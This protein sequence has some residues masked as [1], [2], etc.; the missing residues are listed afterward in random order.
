M[1]GH[2][3]KIMISILLT[4]METAMFYDTEWLIANRFF[5][6]ALK[7]A[8][9]PMS[10]LVNGV[11]HVDDALIFSRVFCLDCLTLLMNQMCKAPLAF[12]V[13]SIPPSVEFLDTIVTRVGNSL[14]LTLCQ[15]NEAWA[16][17]LTDTIAKNAAPCVLGT[18]VIARR[19]ITA[20]ISVK[21]HRLNQLHPLG[22][23]YRYHGL[24]VIVRELLRLGSPVPYLTRAFGRIRHK[25]ICDLSSIF[26]RIAQLVADKS[27]IIL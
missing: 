1:G 2:L 10:S 3:S 23:R 22:D 15:K 16:L 26:P 9:I 11:R 8:G 6:A 17:G 14:R 19:R 18:P 20:Y 12:S 13:E 7:E 24:V 4:A 25:A 27:T 21:L 5:F